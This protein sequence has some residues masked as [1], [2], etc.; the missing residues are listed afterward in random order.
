MH[1]DVNTV[2]EYIAA[3]PE[4]RRSAIEKFRK[5]ILSNLPEALR[6]KSPMA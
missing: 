4:D 5:T 1:Y 6:N 2:E 3:L